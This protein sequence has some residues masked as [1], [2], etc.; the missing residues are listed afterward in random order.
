MLIH[1]ATS[2]QR[3]DLVVYD[4]G[5][6]NQLYDVVVT[7]PVTARGG[8]YVLMLI[9]RDIMPII[10]K[11]YLLLVAGIYIIGNDWNRWNAEK[12]IDYDK[13]RSLEQSR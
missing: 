13:Y 3:M 7:N 12:R 11:L 5:H 6:P 8:F 1:Q 10:C 2:N 9:I 4:S